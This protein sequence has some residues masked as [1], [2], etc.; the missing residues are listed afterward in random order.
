[1]FA[2]TFYATDTNEYNG[3]AFMKGFDEWSMTI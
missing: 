3:L 1:M 2:H